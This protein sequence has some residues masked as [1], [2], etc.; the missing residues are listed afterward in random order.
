MM[1]NILIF[2][3]AEFLAEESCIL[4]FMNF[5]FHSYKDFSIIITPYK[6]A[7]TWGYS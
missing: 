3:H 6:H 5:L 7:H 1:L 2:I 4:T